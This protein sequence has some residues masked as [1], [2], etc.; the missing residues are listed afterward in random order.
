M[1]NFKEEINAFLEKSEG[2]EL[3]DFTNSL[4]Y[5]AISQIFDEETDEI[6]VESVEDAA[7][8]VFEVLEIIKPEL[9]SDIIVLNDLSELLEN[10][11]DTQESVQENTE[12]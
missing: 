10:Y 2:L 4:I 12:N 6:D 7:E 9:K 3:S 5:S 11:L 1:E 8:T